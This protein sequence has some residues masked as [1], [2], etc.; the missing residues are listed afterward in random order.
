MI[1]V[2]HLSIISHDPSR[3]CEMQAEMLGDFLVRV[4]A[5]DMSLLDDTVAIRRTLRDLSQRARR[6]SS[7]GLGCLDVPALSHVDAYDA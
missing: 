3:S 5:C 2:L 6:R 7:M 4:G 1:I